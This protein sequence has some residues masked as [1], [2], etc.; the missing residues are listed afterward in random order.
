MCYFEQF[1]QVVAPG[2]SFF[3]INRECAEY[4]CED[5]EGFY[6]MFS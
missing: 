5:A 1:D 2:D 6:I 4:R 3:P